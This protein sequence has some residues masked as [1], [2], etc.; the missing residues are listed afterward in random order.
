MFCRSCNAAYIRRKEK[1]YSSGTIRP[2]E[3]SFSSFTLYAAVRQTLKQAFQP[4]CGTP[5]IAACLLPG[6]AH[7]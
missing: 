2:E 4:G 3:Y 5:V 6:S 1:E 7:P